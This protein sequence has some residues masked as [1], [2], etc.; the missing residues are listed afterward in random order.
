MENFKQ[1]AGRTAGEHGYSTDKR[2]AGR[3]CR[4]GAVFYSKRECRLHRRRSIFTSTFN[5][6]DGLGK[7][8]VGNRAEVSIT[9][10]SVQAARDMKRENVNGQDSVIVDLDLLLANKGMKDAENIRIQ[11]ERTDGKTESG[12]NHYVPLDLKQPLVRY[13]GQ[14]GGKDL[15]EAGKMGFTK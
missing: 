15:T 9:E 4:T 8:V 11:L 3:Y 12:E 7:I 2:T 10:I 5:K 13:E 1:C 6:D 14:S